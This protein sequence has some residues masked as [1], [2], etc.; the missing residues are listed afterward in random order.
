MDYTKITADPVDGRIIGQAYMRA[1]GEITHKVRFAYRL[2][3]EQVGQ[4]YEELTKSVRVVFQDDDPYADASEMFR[5]VRRGTLLIYRTTDEQSHPVLSAD[6]NNRF[7]AVHD[8]FGHFRSGRG[9]DRHGEEAAW[10]SHSQMFAGLARRA[11][12]S[13]TRG[14]N[15]AFIWINGG[16]EFPPQKAVLLPGWMSI[17]PPRHFA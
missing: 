1:S 15:S 11:M 16:R 7:R 13:E 3:A 12:T 5:D 17:I 14:Q 6:E 8:Y 2:F 4:Q 10:V 9:F